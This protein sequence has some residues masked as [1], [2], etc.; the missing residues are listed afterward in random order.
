MLDFIYFMNEEADNMYAFE[1]EMTTDSTMT[2]A[3][4]EIL[5]KVCT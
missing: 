4:D 3:H 1:T 2:H 5:F